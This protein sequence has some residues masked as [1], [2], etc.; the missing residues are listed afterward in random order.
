MV[1]LPPPIS[2]SCMFYVCLIC[3]LHLMYPFSMTAC[4]LSI[5][6]Y[7][8]FYIFMY[9]WVGDY[10]SDVRDWT[11]SPMTIVVVIWFTLWLPWVCDFEFLPSSW[12][13]VI[14]WFWLSTDTYRITGRRLIVYM[15][16]TGKQLTWHTS[17]LIHQVL[18]DVFIQLITSYLLYVSTWYIHRAWAR[19]EV[20]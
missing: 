13:C 8:Y 1:I 7:M 4:S 9:M 19:W 14:T 6:R 3:I 18:E 12:Q 20:E 15:Y 17:P 11:R 2:L 16:I 10:G 5:I